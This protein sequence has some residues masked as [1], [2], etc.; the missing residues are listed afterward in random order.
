[1]VPY[2][3]AANRADIDHCSFQVQNLVNY[4][5][6]PPDLRCC[7]QHPGGTSMTCSRGN[8]LKNEEIQPDRRKAMEINEIR[9]I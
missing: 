6:Q 8:P 1:M 5:L 7:I 4:S 9:L 2:I 3:T